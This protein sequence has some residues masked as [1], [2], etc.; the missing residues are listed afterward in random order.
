MITRLCNLQVGS[1]QLK[2][3]QDQLQSCDGVFGARFSGAGTRGAC[4]AL[5]QA[6][7]TE[8]VA[9]KVIHRPVQRIFCDGTWST[10]AACLWEHCKLQLYVPPIYWCELCR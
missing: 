7:A 9:A 10:C 2:F 1:P 6:D 5:V 3:L 8:E 4:V